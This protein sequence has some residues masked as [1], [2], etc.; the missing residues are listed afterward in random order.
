[1]PVQV[2]DL[3]REHG[4]MLGGGV[5]E[6]LLVDP[7]PDH[8]IKPGRVINHRVRVLGDRRLGGVPTDSELCCRRG[9]REPVDVHHL[10]QPAPRPPGQRRPWSDRVDMLGPCAHRAQCFAAQPTAPGEHQHRR[11]P[12]DRQIPHLCALSA[13]TDR[14]HPTRRAP[15]PI[16]LGLH[17]QPPL[18]VAQHLRAHDQSGH[19]DERGR[20]VATVIH[21]QGSLLQQTSD[22]CRM[23]RPLAALVDPNQPG[24]NL[25]P[26]H[27]SSRRAP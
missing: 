4:A 1:M 8:T 27:T 24:P 17:Q 9:D 15:R 7:D 10:G 20:V 2:D 19:P 13:M 11:R 22:I 5:Q 25:T 6:P 23:A 14:T 26:P 16:S 21:G 18:A 3:G 12:R